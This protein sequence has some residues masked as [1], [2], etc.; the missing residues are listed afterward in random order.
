MHGKH[1]DQLLREYFGESLAIDEIQR[2]GSEKE[3]LYRELIQED[4]EQQLLPGV[5]QF[6]SK[7]Q[8]MP[9]AVASNAEEANVSF[10][11]DRAGLRQHFLYAVDGQQV[12]FGKPN[13]EVYLKTAKLLQVDPNKCIVFEDSQTGIDAAVSA[14]MKVVAINS[15]RTTLIGQAIEADHFLD[16][17]L[18][19]WLAQQL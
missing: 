13:P 2:M 6:L 17:R 19:E 8:E 10:V 16:T 3:A 1:N 7:H 12:E 18:Q 4:L 5:R 14:G 11:L 15:H 9:K